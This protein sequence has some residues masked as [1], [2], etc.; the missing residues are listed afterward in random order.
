MTE[1][2]ETSEEKKEKLVIK[3][4]GMSYSFDIANQ[5]ADEELELLAEEEKKRSKRMKK[6]KKND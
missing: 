4:L 5:L 3:Y 6:V 2:I 1:E